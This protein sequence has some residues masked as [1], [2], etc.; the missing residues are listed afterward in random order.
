MKE[1]IPKSVSSLRAFLR[2][3]ISDGGVPSPN[4]ET[5]RIICG[6]IGRAHV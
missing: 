4:L 5:D 2:R 6:E 1:A 3:V